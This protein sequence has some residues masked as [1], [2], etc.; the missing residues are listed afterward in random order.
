MPLSR[1]KTRGELVADVY[2]RKRGGD[3]MSNLRRVLQSLVRRVK[4]RGEPSRKITKAEEG[5]AEADPT[6][7]FVNPLRRKRGAPNRSVYFR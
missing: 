1:R 7:Y 3:D 2:A 5:E 4:A 6:R